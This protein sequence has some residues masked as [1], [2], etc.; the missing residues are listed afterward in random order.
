M[1]TIMIIKTIIWGMII[2]L[3]MLVFVLISYLLNKYCGTK[4]IINNTAN[5][6]EESHIEKSSLET[7]FDSNW[8]MLNSNL[9]HDHSM[10]NHNDDNE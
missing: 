6:F 5:M 3:T 7:N 9:W 8:R 4:D 2:L 1:E 10:F